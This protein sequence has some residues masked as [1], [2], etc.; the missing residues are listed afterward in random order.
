MTSHFLDAVA[1]S[2]GLETRETPVGFKFIG[3]Y[4]RSGGFL[5]GG[6]ESGGISIRGHVPE[7]DGLLACLLMDELVAFDRKPLVR[8]RQ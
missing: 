7:K 6:E 8:I 3:E 1:K 5:L 4:L 2:H